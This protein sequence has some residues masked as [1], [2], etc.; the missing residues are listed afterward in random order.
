MT[1]PEI[2]EKYEN[3]RAIGDAMC[4][5]LVGYTY[6]DPEFRF[7]KGTAP[8]KYWKQLLNNPDMEVLA[9]CD[10]VIHGDNVYT[11]T[12]TNIADHCYQASLSRSKLNGRRTDNVRHHSNQLTQ[13]CSSEHSNNCE[14]CSG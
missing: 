2:F 6:Q 1:H 14:H 4:T 12:Y 13:P 5:A 9:V 8:L 3:P 10:P 11:A 7:K